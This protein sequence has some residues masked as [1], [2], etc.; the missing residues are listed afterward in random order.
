MSERPE[1]LADHDADVVLVI[2]YS[3]E[4][5]DPGLNALLESPLSTNLAASKAGEAHVI[6]G[7]KTVGAAWARMDRFLDELEALLLPPHL[8]VDVVTESP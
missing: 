3:G 6:D 4:G 2:D 1:N 7:T 8:R 5:Q